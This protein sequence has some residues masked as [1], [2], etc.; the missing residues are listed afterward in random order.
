MFMIIWPSRCRLS[1][2]KVELWYADAVANFELNTDDYNC[3]TIRE[4][5]MALHHAGLITLK[6]NYDE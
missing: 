1:A 3:Q 6:G 5:A 2:E 4:K